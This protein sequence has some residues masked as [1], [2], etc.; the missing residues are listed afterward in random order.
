MH[1]NLL[2][3]YTMSWVWK[4]LQTLHLVGHILH[5]H[6]PKLFAK[7][8]SHSGQYYMTWSFQGREKLQC[9]LFQIQVWARW[10]CSDTLPGCRHPPPILAK[11]RLECVRGLQLQILW[12]FG[13]N[14]KGNNWVTQN[15]KL[16]ALPG[17]WEETVP[18][19]LWPVPTRTTRTKPLCAWGGSKASALA[20]LETSAFTGITIWRGTLALSPHRG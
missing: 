18:S 17:S 11:R 8:T 13:F 15:C 4:Y 2:S 5:V 19:A 6:W 9:K 1:S 20:P 12:C 16:I 3:K 14:F 10:T 7:F